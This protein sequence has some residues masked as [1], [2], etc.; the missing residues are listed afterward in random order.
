MTY[1][2]YQAW[3]GEDKHTEWVNG[4]VIQFGPSK[5][6]HQSVNGFLHNLLSAYVEL[7][8]LG[9]IGIAPIEVRVIKISY[10][11]PDIVFVSKK[12]MSIVN[13]DRIEGAPDLIIEI[14]SKDSVQRDREDKYDEYEA[15]GVREYWIIDNRP[16]RQSAEFYRLNAESH[17]N[18][19]ELSN[20]VFRSEVLPNF[21]L[22][23]DWLWEK[24]P[25]ALNALDEIV[26]LENLAKLA[27][28]K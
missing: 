10:R 18:R 19:I 17:Y 14:V 1:E 23:T 25:N 11:E 9:Y 5:T 2:E 7:F 16:R 26:G 3:S 24:F 27:K 6:I 12:R 4:K 22:R 15:A 13:D 8:K 28:K 21:W 20:G